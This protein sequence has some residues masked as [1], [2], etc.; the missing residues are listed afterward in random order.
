MLITITQEDIDN[1]IPNEADSCPV[2]RAIRRATGQPVRVGD[3]TIVINREFIYQPPTV[4]QFVYDFDDG[5]YTVNPFSFELDYELP[6]N[7]TFD[8]PCTD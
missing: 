8:L 4:R 5:A 2:A 6:G 7:Y 3:C 1:G